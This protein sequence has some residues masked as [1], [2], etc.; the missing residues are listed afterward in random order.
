[1]IH[2]TETTNRNQLLEEILMPHIC[3]SSWSTLAMTPQDVVAGR[4]MGIA[5]AA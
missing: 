4:V 3:G 1:V 5:T 2:D